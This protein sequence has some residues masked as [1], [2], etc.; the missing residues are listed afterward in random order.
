MYSFY[1]AFTTLSTTGYGDI[2]ASNNLEMGWSIFC[3]VMSMFVLSSTINTLQQFT[4]SD[5][6]RHNFKAQVDAL[7][8]M[9]DVPRGL[10][11]RVQ[12]YYG[13]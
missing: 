13:E 11:I 5:D 7:C 10:K 9:K 3:M 4:A 8:S 12:E 2:S 1:W 6:S